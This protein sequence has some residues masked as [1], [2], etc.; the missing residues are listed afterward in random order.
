MLYPSIIYHAIITIRRYDFPRYTEAIST[1]FFAGFMYMIFDNFGPMVGWWIWDT[2]DPTTFPYIS[3]VPLTSYAWM[4][5]TV[6]PER[7]NQNGLAMG[8]L[9]V[10]IFALAVST[11]ILLLS[12][13]VSQPSK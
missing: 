4:L 1:G 13:P 6:T 8:N 7:L 9:V 5:Y 10:V 11:V 12:H 2:S 3:S